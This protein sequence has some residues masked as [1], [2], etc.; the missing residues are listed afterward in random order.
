MNPSNPLNPK[1]QKANETQEFLGEAQ[2][3]QRLKHRED[4][5]AEILLKDLGSG[6]RF[7]GLGFRDAL[8]EI[9]LKDLLALLLV[10]SWFFHMS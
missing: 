7:Y 6:F 5:L 2:K 8:A 10:F 9:L 1:P 3:K 4:A